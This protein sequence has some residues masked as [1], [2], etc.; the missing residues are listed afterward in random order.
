LVSIKVAPRQVNL[1]SL[2][3]QADAS[4][5]RSTGLRAEALEERRR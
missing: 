5:P 2:L 1:L 4:S 3:L